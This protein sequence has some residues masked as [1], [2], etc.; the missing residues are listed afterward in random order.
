MGGYKTGNGSHERRYRLGTRG[1]GM[2]WILSGR[3]GI[4]VTGGSAG[5]GSQRDS[6]SQAAGQKDAVWK[7]NSALCRSSGSINC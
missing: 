6:I 2:E 4:R 1:G 5:A 3:G 7:K